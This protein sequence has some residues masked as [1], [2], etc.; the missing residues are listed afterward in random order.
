MF[1]ES[2]DYTNQWKQEGGII[3]PDAYMKD[4]IQHPVQEKFYKMWWQL[5]TLYTPAEVSKAMGGAA[6]EAVMANPKLLEYFLWNF[7]QYL[8]PT[9]WGFDNRPESLFVSDTFG[10]GQAAPPSFVMQVFKPV[11]GSGALAEMVNAEASTVG[12]I[13]NAYEI[14]RHLYTYTEKAKP[15]M[16][17]LTWIGFA[18]TW[19]SRNYVMALFA[20]G[21]LYYALLPS[22]IFPPH[23][24]YALCVVAFS[25][26]GAALATHLIYS[27][28][29]GYIQKEC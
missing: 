12:I 14:M 26:M 25:L 4:F 10:I 23:M 28:F 27:H 3:D 6:R 22:P 29:R 20:G 2:L 18:L 11:L 1:R 15:L 9:S 21:I 5:D 13:K 16:V 7:I 17:A 8:G 24:R 19:R